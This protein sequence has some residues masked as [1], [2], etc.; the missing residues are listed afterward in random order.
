M[1]KIFLTTEPNAMAAMIYLWVL[2]TFIAYGLLYGIDTTFKKNFVVKDFFNL[3]KIKW[4][5][6]FY[7]HKE[8]NVLKFIFWLNIA[9]HIWIVSALIFNIAFEINKNQI[10]GVVSAILTLGLFFWWIVIGIF[11]YYHKAQFEKK[12]EKREKSEDNN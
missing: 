1:N 3:G 5:F 12:Y 7:N 8:G 2:F 10:I 4:L 6:C 11:G 9:T